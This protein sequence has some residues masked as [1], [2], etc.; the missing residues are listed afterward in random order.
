MA[1]LSPRRR[2][3]LTAA[4]IYALLSLTLLVPGLLP[5]K[6]ISTADSLYFSVPWAAHRPASLHRPT[7]NELGDSVVQFQPFTAYAKQ[8]LP[9]VPLWDP[10]IMSGRPF[11]ADDQSAVF[12]PFSLPAYLLP[13]LTSLAWSAALKLFVAAFGTFLLARALGQRWGA[14]LLAGLIYGFSFWMITWLAYPHSSV[15]AVFPWML[16][17]VEL[18]L[19]RPDPLSGAALATTIGVQFLCGHAESSFDMLVATVAFFVLRTSQRLHLLRRIPAARRWLRLAPPPADDLAGDWLRRVLLASGLGAVGGAAVAALMLIPFVALT[20]ASADIHQRAGT[21]VNQH[22]ALR[23]LLGVFLPD[24]WGRATQTPLI[25]FIR[26]QAYYVGALPLLLALAALV[27]RS[28]AERWWIA[29]FGFTGLAVA[30]GIPPFL[31]IVTHLPVFSSGH[32]SRL[33]PWYLLAV[34]LLAGWGVQDLI[35]IRL[36]RARRRVIVVLTAAALLTPIVTVLA[37]GEIHQ[38]DP[39]A[40]LVATGLFKAPGIANVQAPS[41]IHLGSLLAWI[42]L[43]GTGVGLILLRAHGRLRPVVFIGAALVLTTVDLFRAGMGYNPGVAQAQAQQPT[44]GAIRYLEA[45]RQTRFQGTG[46]F[47]WN[48]IAQRYS[49]EEAGGYDVPI[50]QR[51]DHLWRREVDP[52][53]PSQVGTT[54]ADI[55]LIMPQVDATGLHTLRM[56]GVGSL[57]VAPGTKLNLPGVRLAYRGRDASVYSVADPQPRVTVVGAARAVSSAGAAFAAVIASGFDARTTAVTEGPVPG[58][59][60]PSAGRSPVDGSATIVSSA[61]E[62]VT[63]HATARHAGLLVLDDSYAP[64]WTA[65]VDGHPAAVREVDYVLRGVALGPGRHTIVFAY[66]PLSWRLGVILSLVALVAILAALTIGR[67]RRARGRRVS[68]PA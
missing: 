55:P 38:L 21:A 16:W 52:E 11:L 40:L 65:T 56:L 46:D 36:N 14:A 48:V 53:H 19:K 1:L 32:N 63:V 45:H 66:R 49:L 33:I 23:G 35:A 24:Y 10:Y 9:H 12:S 2:P 30:V 47:P 3:K 25:D 39:R 34:A 60:A 43:A 8:Q 27:I 57:L 68:C 7:N 26:A 4:L 28:R 5:G 67:R 17:S 44:T 41:I 13:L 20:L 15:W 29:L 51:Y 54:F 64:G 6:T 61:A 22:L 58:V 18:V 50:P 31:Q 37:R 42:G 62:R 59:P